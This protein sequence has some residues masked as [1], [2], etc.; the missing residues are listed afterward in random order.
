MNAIRLHLPL[1]YWLACAAPH[2]WTFSTQRRKVATIDT[3]Y[4]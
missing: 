4:L 2:Y 1:F 3:D